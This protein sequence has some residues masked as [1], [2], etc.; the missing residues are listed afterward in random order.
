[1]CRRLRI[2]WQKRWSTFETSASLGN[3]ERGRE[4]EY[5]QESFQLLFTLSPQLSRMTQPVPE[6]DPFCNEV[7]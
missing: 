6:T 4:S 3:V 5:S 2:A 7:A 1:M